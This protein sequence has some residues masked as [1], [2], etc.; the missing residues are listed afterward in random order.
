MNRTNRLIVALVALSSIAAVI[1]SIATTADVSDKDA[2]PAAAAA[3]AP[4]QLKI[5]PG[6]TEAD[7]QACML[8][9]TPGKMHERLARDAGAWKGKT[10][11]W[12]GPGDAEP[13]TGECTWTLTPVMEGRYFKSEMT[14]D[15]PGMGPYSGFGVSGFDNVSQEFVSTWIDN[16]STGILTGTGALSDDGKTLTW[17]F[18]YN[19]PITKKPTIIRQIETTTGENTKTLEMFGAEPKSGKEYKMMRIELTRK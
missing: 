2:K 15:M 18:T 7:V 1:G 13:M 11:M 17:K 4:P 3:G 12:M 5:P 9:G 14:G 16:H 6:W 10:T 8:A 19:C